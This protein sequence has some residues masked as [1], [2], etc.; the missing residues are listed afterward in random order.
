MKAQKGIRLEYLLAAFVIALIAFFAYQQYV[1]VP[2]K[3]A[4]QVQC[5]PVLVRQYGLAGTQVTQ[6]L[7]VVDTKGN[8]VSGANVYSFDTKPYYWD[9]PE[10]Y[11]YL[12][13]V[14]TGVTPVATTDANGQA[15]ISVTI[16]ETSS[17]SYVVLKTTGYWTE[18]YVFT[19]S[20]NPLLAADS[21]AKCLEVYT[22]AT[23]QQILPSLVK[24]DAKRLVDGQVFGLKN[25][26]VV[27][28]A[29][30]TTVNPISFGISKDQLGA[31]LK[32]VSTFYIT[33]GEL[34]VTGI[35]VS[36]STNL[37]NEGVKQVSLRI[38][39]GGTEIFN[40][41]VFDEVNA[42]LPLKDGAQGTA[43]TINVQN[44]LIRAGEGQSV[45]IEA[46]VIADTSATAAAGDNRLGPNEQILSVSLQL[47]D[48]LTGQPITI[49]IK[50]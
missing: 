13:S 17:V 12:G 22:Y 4:A 25:L 21:E 43:Y 30:Y 14:V 18:P 48:P 49:A 50:G 8:A 10:L 40:G 42:N 7:K 23:V 26:Q 44:G 2:P 39:V 36:T 32:G 20:I 29:T 35:K 37:K 45:V 3:P 34:R 31:N 15:N 38:V 28:V 41:L 5:G 47:A 24:V 11:Q 6:T 33:G 1:A 16:P 27:P 9:K 46:N 19:V